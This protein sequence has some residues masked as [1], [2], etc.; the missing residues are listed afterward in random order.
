MAF[1]LLKDPDVLLSADRKRLAFDL[2]H[3]L[4]QKLRAV[5]KGPVQDL[6]GKPRLVLPYSHH[7]FLSAQAV[8]MALPSPIRHDYVWKGRFKPFRHQVATAAFFTRYTK[9]FCFN[10]LGVGKTL[11]ALW[12]ADFLMEQGVVHKALVLS[13]LSTLSPTW[14]SEIFANFP[15]RRYHVLHGRGKALLKEPGSFFIA[16]HEIVRD[17]AFTKKILEDSLFDLLIVDECAM[18]RNGQTD[19]WKG[20]NVLTQRMARVWLMT[21]AP[22]P[23]SPTD[24]WAQIRL[25]FPDRV[26]R[27][28]V[29]FRSQV[30]VARGPYRWEPKPDAESTIR[31]LMVPCIRF[32]AK[33]CIDLP[34]LTFERRAVEMTA[35][36]KVLYKTMAKQFLI[37]LEGKQITAANEAVLASKLLQLGCGIAIHEEGVIR[38]N[39][40]KTQVLDEI[41]EQTDG[42]LIVFAPFISVVNHVAARLKGYKVGVI[43][44]GTPRGERDGLVRSFQH[45]KDGVRILVAQPSTMSH[46]LTLTAAATMV[47][48][49]PV[50]SNDTYQQAVGR[51][52]R[53]GQKRHCTVIELESSPVERA[54]YS[55]LRER[56][57]MQGALLE[58]LRKEATGKGL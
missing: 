37:E 38:I 52:H 6:E 44:G 12:A 19:K 56:Q 32:A 13:P 4:A 47:W 25:L 50:W 29:D 5:V 31:R 36:Q 1:E 39:T 7:V 23:N 3:P 24:A 40:P 27:S 41:I 18:F 28:F 20:L 17:R 14:A 10:D 16:N 11:S 48:F 57:R 33:D 53:Q 35:E 46:G 21:G 9:G 34:P 58:L 22:T 15:H 8:G 55:R 54:I 42:K 43:T 2:A 45:E 26:S 49:A 30:M 51:I